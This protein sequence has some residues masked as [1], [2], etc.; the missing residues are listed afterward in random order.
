[1]HWEEALAFSE[2]KVRI[3]LDICARP[4]RVAVVMQDN[5]DPDALAS[6]LALRHM[7]STKL[8]KRV[9]IA[10]G[11][12][13]GRAENRAMLD[14]LRIGAEHLEPQH[15]SRF[16]T[17]L[18]VDAQPRA[19][20][21]TLLGKRPADVV[22]DHHLLAKRR[23][24][25]ARLEDVRPEYGATSTILYEY[26]C[27][28]KIKLPANLATALFYGIQ[29]DTQDLG[30]EVSPAGVHA[31]QQL[32]LVADV[33]KL[34]RIRR[35]P[36]PA[37]YYQMLS[38]SLADCVVAGATVISRIR[39]CCNADMLAEV[40]DLLLRLE[41]M[42]AAVCYGITGERILL[43]ARS[44]DGRTNT[45]MR[46]KR[47]VAQLGSG[48]GHHTMAGGQIPLNGDP[49]AR[50]ALVYARI[51]EAFAPGAKPAPLTHREPLASPEM[52]AAVPLQGPTTK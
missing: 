46:M 49:E 34:V 6:A 3:L 41:G 17:L 50:L 9:A 37:A 39:M 38:D 40:A 5:P 12:S 21:L 51:L 28:L 29:S 36:V 24:W 26:L 33:K 22:I 31:Y 8:N 27:A 18:V 52:T 14:V 11:G 45:A 7:V 47:V 48:G 4:G 20:N 2:K 32:F 25:K 23:S 16:N 43:S 1:M 10:Y 19:G 13:I 44:L 30:R 15:L 42:R 35:A